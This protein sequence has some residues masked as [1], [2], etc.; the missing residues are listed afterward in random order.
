MVS[1]S[2]ATVAAYLEELPPARRA[3]VQRVREVLLANLPDGFEEQMQYG[4]IGYAIPLARFPD[5]YNKQPLAVAALAA[6]KNYISVYLHGLYAQ[7]ELAAWFVEAYRATGKKLNMGKSC[8][9]FRRADAAA[10]DVIG[11]AAAKVTPAQLM[12]AHEAAHAAR[13]RR[14]RR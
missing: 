10:L 2:A 12:A 5:T 7:P 11:E 4:M 6:Q 8:V 13:P 3:D 9:R 14:K 1:S